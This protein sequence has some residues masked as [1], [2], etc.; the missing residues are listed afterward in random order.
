VREHYH[1]HAVETFRQRQYVAR[2]H[3]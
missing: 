2:W 3:G 1:R